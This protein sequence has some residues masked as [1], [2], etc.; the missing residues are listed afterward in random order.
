MQKG[1]EGVRNLRVPGWFI[2]A[3]SGLANEFVKDETAKTALQFG[4]KI[5]GTRF[6]IAEE[7]N[8]IPAEDVKAFVQNIRMDGFEDLISVRDGETMVNIMV[9]DKREKLKN[10]L[11]LVNEED[12]FVFMS[13][14]SRIKYEDLAELISKIISSETQGSENQVEKEKKKKRKK[15][16]KQEEVAP[17]PV[18]RPRA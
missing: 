4:R 2:Y 6:M 5:G 12:T 14:K 16:K 8:P 10:L 9:K 15:K 13:M 17:P 3:A 1:K 11:I 18:V 7:A